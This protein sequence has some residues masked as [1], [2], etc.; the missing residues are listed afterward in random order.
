MWFVSTGLDRAAPGAVELAQREPLLGG[1]GLGECSLS[2]ILRSRAAV[3]NR[4]PHP[5][6]R[7]E[8]IDWLRSLVLFAS[9]L[10]ST[11]ATGRLFVRHQLCPCRRVRFQKELEC[12]RP[13]DESN[14]TA[15]L[16]L[17]RSP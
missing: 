12:A 6:L 3:G 14:N 13:T 5:I 16:N 9:P 2:E 7:D 4:T 15:V 1:G 17:A 10:R 11:R 8:G